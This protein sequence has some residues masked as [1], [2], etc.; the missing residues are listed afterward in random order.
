MLRFDTGPGGEGGG[1]V[2]VLPSIYYEGVPP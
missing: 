1:G 2:G